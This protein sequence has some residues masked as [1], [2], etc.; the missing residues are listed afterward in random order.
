MNARRKG[1]PLTTVY[2]FAGQCKENM[3][4]KAAAQVPVHTH[5]HTKKTQ[6]I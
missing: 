2:R 1:A 6:A 4:H 5:I 3:A